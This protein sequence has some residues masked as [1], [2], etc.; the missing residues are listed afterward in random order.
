M[1]KETPQETAF[2]NFLPD[3][4]ANMAKV[5]MDYL[6]YLRIANQHLV[7]LYG[8]RADTIKRMEQYRE[9]REDQAGCRIVSRCENMPILS[10]DDI[11]GMIRKDEQYQTNVNHF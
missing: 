2:R 3:W 5:D 4:F 6:S 11:L 8:A 9:S 7:T 1:R 10:R